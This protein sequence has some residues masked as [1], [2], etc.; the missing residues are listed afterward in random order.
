MSVKIARVLTPIR[1]PVCSRDW[2]NSRRL[3]QDF[4]NAPEPNFTSNTN[5]S[6]PSASFLLMMLAVIKGMEGTVAVTSRKA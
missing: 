1:C 5:A 3:G 6:R 4:I 2:A